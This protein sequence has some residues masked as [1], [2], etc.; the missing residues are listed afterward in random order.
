MGSLPWSQS[1]GSL[2]FPKDLFYPAHIWGIKERAPFHRT[3][4]YWR[5]NTMN[6]CCHRCHC[7]LLHQPTLQ[8]FKSS[9]PCKLQ[10]I[11]QPGHCPSFQCALWQGKWFA[12]AQI[13]YICQPVW[14]SSKNC[15]ERER[16]KK[17]GLAQFALCKLLLGGNHCFLSLGLRSHLFNNV[18]RLLPRTSV[19]SSHQNC[20]RFQDLRPRLLGNVQV[21]DVT[22]LSLSL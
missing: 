2:C 5:F 22:S 17:R 20:L 8:L 10:L 1:W 13:N 9:E 11:V 18:S 14:E 6:N 3:T 16:I 19:S 4:K 15:R 21:T 12:E 7:L